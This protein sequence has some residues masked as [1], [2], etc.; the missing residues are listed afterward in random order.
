MEFLAVFVEG[1]CNLQLCSHGDSQQPGVGFHVDYMISNDVVNT[2]AS[3][4]RFNAFQWHA[5]EKRH[6]SF[7]RCADEDS[8]EDMCQLRA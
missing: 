2:A 5:R 7:G 3:I 6:A 1:R 8:Q 4:L